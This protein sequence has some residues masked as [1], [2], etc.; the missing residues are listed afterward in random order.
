[1]PITADISDKIVCLVDDDPGVLKSIGRLIASDGLPVRPFHSPRE[2][3]AFLQ[4]NAVPLVILDIWMAEMNGLEVQASLGQLSPATRVI[5]IT[6]RDDSAARLTALQ[7][8][9]AGFF[10]KPFDDQ[11]FLAAVRNALNPAEAQNDADV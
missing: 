3:L 1:M 7:N 10:T 11:E 2:F 5:I 6:G 8:G 9:A 4:L